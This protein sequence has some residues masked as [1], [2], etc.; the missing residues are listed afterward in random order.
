MVAD[1]FNSPLKVD[2]KEEVT[3]KWA[4]LHA[5]KCLQVCDHI[6]VNICALC[7]YAVACPVVTLIGISARKPG[8]EFW[9]TLGSAIQNIIYQLWNE[10]VATI[11]NTLGAGEV[12]FRTA[13]TSLSA[14]PEG[15]R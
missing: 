8:V 10:T 9:P 3:S 5:S 14:L 12:C 2:S 6:C 7:P 1:L 4:A 11:F 15:K 13:V